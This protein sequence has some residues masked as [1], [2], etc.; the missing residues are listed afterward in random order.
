MLLGVCDL[1]LGGATEPPLDPQNDV[2][3]AIPSFY[4][5]KVRWEE[6]LFGIELHY[7]LARPRGI[8]RPLHK[9]PSKNCG[10]KPNRRVYVQ[11]VKIVLKYAIKF[12]GSTKI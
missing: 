4:L 1:S 10:P 8:A 11:Y 6:F 5:N 3:L 7:K 12:C 2:C 9:Y